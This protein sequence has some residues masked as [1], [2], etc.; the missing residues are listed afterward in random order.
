MIKYLHI[1]NSSHR[2]SW[3]EMLLVNHS[4]K[5]LDVSYASIERPGSIQNYF[6]AKLI[7]TDISR[8]RGIFGLFKFLREQK[9]NK[10]GVT[11][12]VVAHGLKP[13]ILGLTAKY[14]FNIP[15]GIVHHHQPN[16]FICSANPMSFARK[17]LWE[18]IYTITIKESV[19]VQSLSGEVTRKLLYLN[20]PEKK[21]LKL[22]HGIDV[23]RFSII[24]KDSDLTCKHGTDLSILM[25]GRLSWEK[26]YYLAVD[27]LEILIKSRINASLCIAGIGPMLDDL[28]KYV[29]KRRLS[30]H[31]KFLGWQ[32][33]VA[34]LM[35]QHSV[36]LHTALT[37]SY[38]QVLVESK[39]AGMALVST[40]VGVARDLSSNSSRTWVSSK[41]SAVELSELIKN[42]KSKRATKLQN[43]KMISVDLRKENIDYIH[44]NLFEFLAHEVN[45]LILNETRDVR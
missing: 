7:P 1:G 44:E 25:V 22:G 32:S 36:F 20:Y 30:S 26:N 4:K 41:F 17:K 8:S 3:M 16:Y 9:K 27:T 5:G 40:D 19:F 14:L 10:M 11:S 35:C 2:H 6:Q 31:V 39:L 28:S 24:A 42:I 18:F 13:S 33:D 21:I 45:N 23:Q 43:T 38:G 15:Y 34:S 29:D 37:E 12:V